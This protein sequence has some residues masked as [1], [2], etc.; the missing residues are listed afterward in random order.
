MR[1]HVIQQYSLLWVLFL[2]V[3]PCVVLSQDASQPN[4]AGPY[5]IR[6]SVDLVVLQITV[7]D[8]KGAP[9]SGLTKENFQ[10]MRTKFCKKLILLAMKIYPSR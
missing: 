7:R 4:Q 6:T 3:F 2:M 5:A 1:R 8:H 10:S 9:V